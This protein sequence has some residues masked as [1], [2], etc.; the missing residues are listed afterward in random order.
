MP[1][2]TRARSKKNGARG[3]RQSREQDDEVPEVYREMLAEAEARD[4][5]NLENDRPIKKRKV[6][7]QSLASPAPSQTTKQEDQH[8]SK[9]Q[10]NVNLQVQT[11][12]DSSS[13]DESEMEWEEVDILQAPAAPIQTAP[14]PG[15]NETMQ[16]TL[17]PHQDQKRKV[18][19][20][21]KPITATEREMRLH[22]HKAHL[23]CLLS[24][25]Q[26]RNLWC[27]DEEIQG[28]LKQ[29]LTK[30]VISLLNP[31]Q[32]QPQ[33]T[34]STTFIDGLNQASDAFL[35]RFRVI[36]SGL[37]RAHWADDSL[38]LKQRVEDIMSDAEMFLSKDDFQKQAKTLQGSR[39]FGAQLFC[40][41]LR[42]VA[43]E[44]R[45]VCSLQPLPFTGTT[46]Q[47]T[48]TKPGRQVI[49]MSS[50]DLDTSTDDLAK[51]GASPTPSRTRRLGRPQFKPSTQL[52]SFVA[53]SR[54][55]I[56]ESSFP[57]FW[58]EAFNE[59]M[60]KWVPVDPLVTKSIAKSFKF[61][62]PS[63]DPYN[64][65]SYVIAFEE[66]ASARD[67]TRRYSKAFN[68]K[69]R[70]LRVESTK[71]G[72]RWWGRVMRF[73]E[74]PFLEDRDEVEISEL[75]AKIAAEPMPR[76][77][78][79]FKDH[80]IYALGRHLRRHEAIFP[81]RVVGQVSVGKSGSRNQ[82][83]EP[84]Y[85]RSDV[86]AL[87]SANRWFRLGRD[88]KVGEQPLKRVQSHRNQVMAIEEDAGDSE[89]YTETALYAYHQTELY[90]PPSV[91]QGKVPKNAFGN[92]D[93]YVPSMVPSGGVHIKHSDARHAAKLLGIDYA[94]AVTGFDFKGRHGTAVIQ[95]VVIAK[96]YE[97]AL[98]EVLGC[99][100]D[101]K[102]QAE[103]EQKSAESLRLWKHFLLKL[104]IAERV[105]SY[106]VEGEEADDEES[107]ASSNNDHGSPEETGGGF[108]PE[109]NQETI[110]SQYVAQE[111]HFESPAAPKDD[112][113]LGGRFIPNDGERHQETVQES[114]LEVASGPS[115]TNREEQSL[116]SLVVMSDD[117]NTARST[118]PYQGATMLPE[119]SAPGSR[120][121]EG[122]RDGD[123][124]IPEGVP[125]DTPILVESS[126]AADTPSGSVKVVSQPLSATQSR[127]ESPVTSDEESN[128][129]DEGSLLSH[130]PEDEDAIPE[131]LMS[132]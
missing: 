95:G 63:S 113:L 61:E 39:D 89:Q 118:T 10:E 20:R 2:T 8:P 24:H 25:A 125:S 52:K 104:R 34:R 17:D 71:N 42:S 77:L 110:G 7:G 58:V 92:L 40:A 91:I 9:Q 67:V 96:E 62:P 80:P 84:V 88:I 105:Q 69:T 103:L 114:V 111:R 26:L 128:S 14:A 23:L 38:A 49:V 120:D 45:L 81:K 12:Y 82:V 6:Q 90:R 35:K 116:Y 109:P 41:L 59:A 66:D 47:M 74:K 51:R 54:P 64:C 1:R 57:V 22:V 94:D 97:E 27:N 107:V 46:K 11:V 44:A 70:K 56:R 122:H 93:V 32:E 36:K 50:D 31:S 131:W 53:N 68:A 112:D 76:N 3:G 78:Q 21:R 123:R 115:H 5:G 19:R 30:R 83:L 60:Q 129:N 98:K 126:T 16:I 48:P 65:M 79:D 108:I 87:R 117:T 4:P 132:D 75:T 101:Q 100:E 55:S 29:M 124:K 130:D 28:F 99:L 121:K 73:Y 85:R 13:S 37:K 102:L 33:Y 86:H 119:A 15:E 106:A 43:V 72:E 18:I 127:I